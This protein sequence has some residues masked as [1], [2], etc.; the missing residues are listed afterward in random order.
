MVV[1]RPICASRPIDGAGLDGHA[2]L[3]P[4]ARMDRRLAC[5]RHGRLGEHGVRV[6][7]LQRQ[8]EPAVGLG[9]DQRHRA[10]RHARGE[11]GGDEAGGGPRG[12]QLAQVL[13]VVEEGDVAG[14]GIGQ[15]LH[16]MDEQTGIGAGA[17]L[18]AGLLRQGLE[19]DRRRPL[20]ETRMLHP[21]PL[22]ASDTA[23]RSVAPP[24]AATI[25]W[26]SP[27]VLKSRPAWSAA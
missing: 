23:R 20:E 9:H 2:L 19:A 12:R 26:E 1:P 21:A 13:A 16:V 10:R 25:A 17:K 27:L 7:E 15:P 11:S 18:R 14:T 22:E 6:E 8:G 5:A 3:Q 24:R 4:R